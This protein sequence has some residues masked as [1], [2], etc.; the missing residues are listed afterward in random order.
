VNSRRNSFLFATIILVSSCSKQTPG[1][2]IDGS[3][4]IPP[5]PPFWKYFTVEGVDEDLDGVRDDVEI[6]I[7]DE[8]EDPNIRKAMKWVSN[9]S[10]R[11]M[12]M[13][14]SRSAVLLTEEARK[15]S[16]CLSIVSRHELAKAK[17]FFP[18]FYF[19]L[20]KK[21][22][23]NWWRTQRRDRAWRNVPSGTYLVSLGNDMKMLAEC[24]FKVINLKPI[25]QH[26]YE[27]KYY[28][29][30]SSPEERKQFLEDFKGIE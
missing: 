23:N 21:L 17:M 10:Y 22:L 29:H 28:E 26:S 12:F 24:N 19:A 20:E 1:N 3:D 4:K 2:F 25:Y 9:V 8:Y 6:W 13:D 14:N 5:S 30:N 18:D 11:M 16:D 7:N 15:A 27:T